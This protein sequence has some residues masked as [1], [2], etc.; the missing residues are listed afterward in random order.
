E[1]PSDALRVAG[2]HLHEYNRLL[3]RDWLETADRL[4]DRNP[5]GAWGLL[6]AAAMYQPQVIPPGCLDRFEPRRGARP[7][8]YLITMLSLPGPWSDRAPELL[9]RALRA[10][11]EHP[12]EA[13]DASSFVAGSREDLLTPELVE[14]V[15]RHFDAAPEKAWE[16][17]ERAVRVKPQIFDDA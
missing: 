16:F 13:V 4:F 7:R 15:A 14:A 6:G 3:D 11:P 17:F 8:Y 9:A 2:H 5:E 1:H 10:F 12:K